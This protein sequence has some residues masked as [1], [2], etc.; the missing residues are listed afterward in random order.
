MGAAKKAFSLLYTGILALRPGVRIGRGALVDY[1]CDLELGGG[2][3]ELGERVS[4]YKET[5]ILLGRGG[6]CKIGSRSHIAPYGYLLVA[7]KRLEIGSDVAIG[8]FCAIFCSSNHYAPGKKFV[9]YRKEEDIF[10]GD[11][12]LVG[13]QSV[14][15]PGTHIESG[16]VVAANS[17]V[18]GRLESG[19]IYGGSPAKKIGRLP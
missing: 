13:A 11:N 19:W 5:T 9:H 3:L 4:L 12:V 15:L 1:R 2:S 16:V 17:T 14:I 6:R 10:I 7:S 18:S 8:P